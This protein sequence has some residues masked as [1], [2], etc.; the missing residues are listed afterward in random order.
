M[1]EKAMGRISLSMVGS[2]LFEKKVK[3]I[4]KDQLFR[5]I[6]MDLTL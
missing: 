5:M 2:T 6:V 4:T 1:R 3:L